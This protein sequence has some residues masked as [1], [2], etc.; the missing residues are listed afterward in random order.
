[1]QAL[2]QKIKV[3]TKSPV[4]SPVKLAGI[5]DPYT[6]AYPGKVMSK[7][8]ITLQN[9]KSYSCEKEDYPGFHTDPFTWDD[10]IGKFK[11]LT[12]NA[13]DEDRQNRIIEVTRSLD[14]YL[15]DDLIDLLC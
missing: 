6:E 11:R 14:G 3:R 5:L 9:G 13:I 1:M 2:L 4:H 8:E 10:V 15:L 12:A 7:V